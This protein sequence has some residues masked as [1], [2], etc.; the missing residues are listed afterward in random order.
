MMTVRSAR[1]YFS[2]I[3][4]VI[5][6]VT[7]WASTY[8]SVWDGFVHVGREPWGLATLADAYLGFMTF[9]AWVLYRENSMMRKFVLLPV[10]LFFGNIAMSLYV[11][12]LAFKLP[13]DASVERILFNEKRNE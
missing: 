12:W 8:E 2:L 11:L 4:A 5:I 9:Y 7:A 13:A 3:L 6:G 10:I 1:I